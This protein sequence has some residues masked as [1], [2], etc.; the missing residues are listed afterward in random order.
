MKFLFIKKIFFPMTHSSNWKEICFMFTTKV[1]IL[2]AAY[3]VKHTQWHL[4]FLLIRVRPLQKPQTF[5]Q[6]SLQ[7]ILREVRTTWSLQLTAEPYA[8]VEK[9]HPNLQLAH[10][11]YHISYQDITTWNRLKI[12]FPQTHALLCTLK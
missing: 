8:S 2:S 6:H 12:L 10:L 11:C 4:G 3:T 7:W 5:S 1:S 9:T